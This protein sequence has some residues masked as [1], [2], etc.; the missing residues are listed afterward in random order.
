MKATE[1][2]LPVFPPWLRF[3]SSVIS[4][5]MIALAF[6]LIYGVPLL[7][8][9]WLFSQPMPDWLFVVAALASPLLLSALVVLVAGV[10]SLPF[11][12]AVVRAKFPHDL[13]YPLYAMRRLYGIALCAVIYFRPVFHLLLMVRPFK[14]L[15]FRL[16]G[17]RGSMDFTVYPDT[18]IRDLRLLDFG[19]GVYIANRVTLGTNIVLSTGEI[20]SDRITIGENTMIGHLA[21]LGPGVSIGSQT[22]LGVRSMIGI[23]TAIGNKTKIGINVRVDHRCKIGTGVK[24][25]NDVSIGFLCSIGDGVV[26]EE[27]VRIPKG[28]MIPSPTVI[29]CQEDVDHLC[30]AWALPDR[31]AEEKRGYPD[32]SRNRI[33]ENGK[34]D[35][36]SGTES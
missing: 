31:Q 12:A 23:G 16:F 9:Y 36:F 33:P 28:T 8:L 17:Y 5:V 2:S 21:I 18:W 3:L 35:R 30:R 19:K 26:V 20:Y 29:T 10:L 13:S 24:I 25:A 7:A 1:E 27:A 34:R 11:H 22:E 15:F 4:R 32:D 14:T 6:P